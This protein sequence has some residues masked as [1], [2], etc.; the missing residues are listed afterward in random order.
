MFFHVVVVH[1]SPERPIREQQLCTIESFLYMYIFVQVE[2]KSGF[3]YN[4]GVVID[5]ISQNLWLW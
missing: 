1:E 2:K 5:H 3:L 4:T